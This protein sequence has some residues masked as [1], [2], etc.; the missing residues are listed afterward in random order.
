REK[1]VAVLESMIQELYNGHISLNT[2][3]H[4]SPRLIPSGADFWVEKRGQDFIIEGIYKGGKAEKAGLKLSMKVVAY[5]DVPIKEAT[6]NMLPHTVDVPD[7]EVWRYAANVLLAGKRNEERKITVETSEGRIDFFP[8]T[9]EAEVPVGN[10]S[11][12]VLERGIGMIRLHNSLG[13]NQT[14]KDFD[15]ALDA[16]MAQGVHKLILDLRDVPSGGNNTVAKGIM[17][18]FISEE[19]PYQRYRFTDDE[20]ETGVPA[21]WIEYVMPR[22][23]TF[24]GGLVV[25]CNQWTGS[26]GEAMV[27]GFDGMKRGEILGTR[28]AG[29][30]GA[31]GNYTLKNTKIKFQLPITRL[32][33]IDG[34][35]RED[36]RPGHQLREH[37]MCIE[38]ARIWLR[39]QK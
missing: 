29:L 2:N 1:F 31:I 26:I 20:R 18:R 17:G 19:M 33:H 32:Y 28:M 34:T 39:Q 25:L 9:Y 10:L 15:Q 5:N 21:L 13:N 7:A 23:Q 24:E 30:L 3:T 8:D 4:T 16:L 27:I 12:Q 35:P 11:Y 36:F 22:G 38:A 6:Q 37:E 14:I